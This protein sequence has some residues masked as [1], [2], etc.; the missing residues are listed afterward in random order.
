MVLSSE[1]GHCFETDTK[2]KFKVKDLEGLDP[3]FEL[4]EKLQGYDQLNNNYKYGI[5]I[6]QTKNRW[7]CFSMGKYFQLIHSYPLNTGMVLPDNIYLFNKYTKL[8]LESF[9][10]CF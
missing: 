4:V 5:Q 2:R 6:K 7:S 3:T 9:K 8:Y 10:A 1:Y